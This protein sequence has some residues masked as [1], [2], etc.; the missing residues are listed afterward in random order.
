MTKLLFIISSLTILVCNCGNDTTKDKGNAASIIRKD[1]ISKYN[2]LRGTWVRQNKEGFT[3]IEIKD[4][5][6]IL[7]YDFLD[8]EADLQKPT[9]D[10]FWYYKSQATLGYWDSSL[11][12]IATDKFRFDYKLKGDT[13]IEV[14][15]MGDQRTFIKVYTE[16]QKAF[17]DFN[18]A[19]LKGKI[20][21][22][23]RVDPSEFFI[24]D[25]V[26]W[27]YSFTSVASGTPDNKTFSGIATIGDSIMK[28]PYADILTLYKRD[29]KQY[30]K[31]AFVRR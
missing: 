16:E 31:F 8:R 24:L 4:S 29:S 3:L 13:L 23:K 5:S 28:P 22:I 2:G 21:Y 6:N 20:T 26:D 18:E 1:D 12:W 17:K 25:N 7:Y 10:R 9:S 11:I 19:D 15:K 30:L 14:D 27:E